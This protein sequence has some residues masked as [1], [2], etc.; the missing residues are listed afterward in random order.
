MLLSLEIFRSSGADSETLAGDAINSSS[1]RDDP[2]SRHTNLFHYGRMTLSALSPL[3]PWLSARGLRPANLLP[4]ISNLYLYPLIFSDIC[5]I[6]G[7]R[8]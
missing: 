2:H 7:P 6:R 8:S 5:L 3:I 1:L 4:L